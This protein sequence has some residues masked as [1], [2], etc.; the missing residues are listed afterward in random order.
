MVKS[1]VRVLKVFELLAMKR[2]GLTVKDI[3]DELGLP[4]SSTF[5]LISTLFNEGYLLQDH[6]KRYKLG[7][8]LIQIGN[9]AMESLDIASI[10]KPVL[11]KLM[12]DVQET[13]FMAVLSE[14]RLVY[15]LK[16]DS[17][18]SIKTT[19]QPG[20]QKPLHCTGLGKAFLAFLPV[21][22]REKLISTIALQ[23]VTPHTITDRSKL[24]E[25]LEFY[26][27]LGYSI[28]DEENEEGLFC[29]AAPIY[30]GG[31]TVEAAISVAGPKERMSKRKEEIARKLTEA[32]AKL[33]IQMGYKKGVI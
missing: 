7:P 30:G 15:V 3:S 23:P 32:A 2:N 18:R 26:K 8:K 13:V 1:A 20:Y 24:E 12:E 17:N 19:A 25:C 9:N 31:N 21:E 28:D 33:S 10:G 22:K 11:S 14:E 5:H 29:V 4:Q 27:T 6:A 16:I